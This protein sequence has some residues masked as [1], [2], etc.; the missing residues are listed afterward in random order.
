[1][2]T[3]SEGIVASALANA[4]HETGVEALV[5][6]SLNDGK[7][8]RRIYGDHEKAMLMVMRYA[9]HTLADAAKKLLVEIDEMESTHEVQPSEE[10][11]R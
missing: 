3:E 1:M 4:L 11:Q 6:L 10:M 5:L 7:V 2:S 8:T 9:A